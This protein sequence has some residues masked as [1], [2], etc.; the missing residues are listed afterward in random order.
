MTFD[1]D[2]GNSENYRSIDAF[3]VVY[4]V[5]LNFRTLSGNDNERYSHRLKI[6]LVT[7]T[8][9]FLLVVGAF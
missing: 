6:S 7:T 4:I 2:S 3:V 8:Q 1:I 5:S 9:V